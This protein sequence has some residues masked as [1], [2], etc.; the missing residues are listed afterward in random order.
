MQIRTRRE[1]C[2]RKLSAMCKFRGLITFAFGFRWHPHS[3]PSISFGLLCRQANP[4]ILFLKPEWRSGKAIKEVS[5]ERQ[6]NDDALCSLLNHF[7]PRLMKPKTFSLRRKW[8]RAT[9]FNGANIHRVR[10]VMGRNIGNGR[11][12][13]ADMMEAETF[14]STLSLALSPRQKRKL[15]RHTSRSTGA[16]SSVISYWLHNFPYRQAIGINIYDIIIRF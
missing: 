11:R 8:N 7:E 13:V 4:V 14:A 3:I 5:T 6:T 1:R 2:L 12:G 15:P 16:L 10:V 9:R